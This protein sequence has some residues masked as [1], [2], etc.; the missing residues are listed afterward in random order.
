MGGERKVDPAIRGK[1]SPRS[2]QRADRAIAELAARQHGVFST[3]QLLEAGLTRRAIEYRIEARRLY[4]VHRGVLSI[5]PRELMTRN[6]FFMAAVLAGGPG[7]V[8]SHRSAAALWGMRG[9]S[10]GR[11]EITVPKKLGRRLGLRAHR[12]QLPGDEITTVDGI[13]V[14]SPPRTILDLA[15]GLQRHELERT[16]EQAQVLRL[17][18]RLSVSDL[19]DRYPGRRGTATL[20]GLIEAGKV[21][22][23]VTRSELERR[24]LS[25]LEEAGLPLPSTNVHLTADGHTYEVDCLW[26]QERLVVELDSRAFHDDDAAFD[27]DRARDRR[28]AAAGWTTL[29]V[30]WR[31]I[32]EDAAGVLADLKALLTTTPHAAPSPRSP[33][34]AP[35]P[36]VA[37]P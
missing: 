11:V 37:G 26:A 32:E 30:T 23:R 27:R 19:L 5:V 21:R 3:A 10:G 1:H 18:D 29:R 4:R 31:Q 25:L 22:E 14:T 34:P 13:P 9:A 33:P 12:A 24:F 28:L 16:I 15:A 6:A 8:L 35:H 2:G 7:A 36:L 17:Q 20:R